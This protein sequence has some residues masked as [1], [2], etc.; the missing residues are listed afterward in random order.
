MRAPIT[1]PPPLLLEPLR[2]EKTTRKHSQHRVNGNLAFLV[3]LLTFGCMTCF[4]TAWY[5]Y[6]TRWET[7]PTNS[8]RSSAD[9][10]SQVIVTEDFNAND[11]DHTRKYLSYLPHSGFHNQRIAFENAIL[12]S[13][14]LNRTLLVPPIRLGKKPIRYVEYNTLSRFLE[15]SGKEGLLHCP[16]IPVSLSLPL[17]CLQYFESSYVPWTWLINMTTLAEHQL[18]LHLPNLS[19]AWIR[20]HLNLSPRDVYT[21]RDTSPY[22]FRF[23]DT[24]SDSSPP[25]DRY[26]EDI[27]INQLAAVNERLLQIGT[28]FGSS[29]LRLRNEENIAYLK[30]VR[31]NMVF[32]NHDLDSVAER[33]AQ[34]LGNSYLG[35]HLRSADGKFK[36]NVEASI[37]N[38]WWRIVVDTLGLGLTALCE[39]EK[40]LPVDSSS[41]CSEAGSLTIDFPTADP[42]PE[43]GWLSHS[44]RYDGRCRADRHSELRYRVLNIPLYIATDLDSPEVNPS[45]EIF[46]RTFPCL[47]FL[48]D[49][50]KDI[51]PL[52]SLRNS[53]DDVN[54]FSFSLP[55]VE[56]LVLGKA[57][58]VVGTE[59]STFSKYVEN[60][61]WPS[62]RNSSM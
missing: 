24:L 45:L 29:R 38:A 25:T 5:L 36:K 59:G 22:H 18:L 11:L 35:L 46:R 49:F 48:G 7:R 54:L 57:M 37:K 12:L 19:Q 58:K 16:R 39:L 31:R 44:L 42:S 60:V 14:I 47:F 9:L 50:R 56:A 41:R 8:L 17:E 52:E 34:R 23:L 3:A 21:L 32:K 15:L 61:L 27:Y 1:R 28:L 43:A 30:T 4:G 55:F 13:R 33:I 40:F 26:Q 20:A 10:T 53:V 51:E 2:K 6:T 62:F